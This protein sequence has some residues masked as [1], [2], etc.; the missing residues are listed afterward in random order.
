MKVKD[1][2][3]FFAGLPEDADERDIVFGAKDLP[4]LYVVAGANE[5]HFH[6]ED[7]PEGITEDFILLWN[8]TRP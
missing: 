6:E 1:L 2:K 3:Q 7:V 5:S 8:G 4:G